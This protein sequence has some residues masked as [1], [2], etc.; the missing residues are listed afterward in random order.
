MKGTKPKA[1][2]DFLCALRGCS[3][4]SF[5]VKLLTFRE[6]TSMS[7]FVVKRF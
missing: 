2:A 3:F 4:T 7:S 6:W 1:D 5:V